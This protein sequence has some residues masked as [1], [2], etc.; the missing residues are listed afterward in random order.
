VPDLDDLTDRVMDGIRWLVFE[1]IDRFEESTKAIRLVVRSALSEARAVAPPEEVHPEAFCQ[2]CRRPN[3]TWHAPSA[4]WNR[5]EPDNGILC[6]VCF[7]QDARA[8]GVLVWRLEPAVTLPGSEAEGLVAPPAEQ[9]DEA[10]AVRDCLELLAPFAAFWFDKD[11]KYAGAYRHAI[12]VLSGY[13][14]QL[15]GDAAVAPPAGEEP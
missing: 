1:D 8:I 9:R 15:A 6:P 10:T 7:A 14:D 2:R 3:I 4:L 5:A 13:A 11:P 12:D